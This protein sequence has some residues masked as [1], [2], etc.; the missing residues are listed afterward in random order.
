MGRAMAFGAGILSLFL[1]AI[2]FLQLRGIALHYEYYVTTGCES[3]CVYDIWNV[4]GGHPLYAWPNKDFYQLTIYNFAFYYLYAK[5]LNL[6]HAHG[7]QIMLYGRYLTA[8]FAFCGLLIQSWLLWFLTAGFRTRAVK[9]A[10]FL[11]AFCT[12][13]NSYFPGYYDVSVRPDILAAVLSTLGLCFFMRYAASGGMRWICIA[14][15]AWAAAWCFKQSDV[16]CIF[17]AGVYLVVFRKW[18]AAMVLSLTFWIPVGL[19][20]ALGSAAYRWNILA[21]A[22][23][24]GLDF[25]KGLRKFLTG[26]LLSLFTW[27]FVATLPLYLRRVMR[28]DP[29][30]KLKG[31]RERVRPG[32]ELA[33]VAALAFIVLFGGAFSFVALTKNGATLNHMYDIFV[34]A[35]TLSFVLA[36]RLAAMLPAGSARRFSAAACAALLSMCAFPAAQLAMHRTGPI[37]RATE[38]DMAQ[39]ERF[40]LFLK[41]LK[42][43]LFI[44]DEVYSLPWFSTDNQY[45]AV[46]WEGDDAQTRGM[47]SGGL[48][49]LIKKHWFSTLYVPA[50]S[51]LQGEAV[52]A[53]YRKMPITAAQSFYLDSLGRKTG[54]CI[55][56]ELP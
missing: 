3:F 35:T 19:V 44:N 52:A 32:G 34:A 21:A 20:L 39:K 16:F 46:K 1:F 11:I 54:P 45:P 53:G 25:F 13:F 14:A 15:A 56:F 12:W 43:P 28:E 9:T 33:P 26:A 49:A 29:G 47:V 2:L 36:L 42:K 48:D 38:A 17:G 41:S 18:R 23:A 8:G 30:P 7:A 50:D 37:V 40:S 6:L 55:L 27:M 5:A 22:T 24:N 10:I 51:S 4:Q 31:L